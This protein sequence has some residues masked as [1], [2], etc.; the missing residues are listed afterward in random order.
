MAASGLNEEIEMR[1]LRASAVEDVHRFDL[2]QQ[3]VNRQRQYKEFVEEEV[4]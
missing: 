3:E 2:E 1:D 4:S